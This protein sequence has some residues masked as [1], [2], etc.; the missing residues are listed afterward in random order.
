[1]A[2]TAVANNT[3]ALAVSK[4]GLPFTALAP[5]TA[6]VNNQ[7][8]AT[9]PLTGQKIA[10][11][12][13]ADDLPAVVLDG[14]KNVYFLYSIALAPLVVSLVSSNNLNDSN[15]NLTA[16]ILQLAGARYNGNYLFAAVQNQAGDTFGAAGSGIALLRSQSSTSGEKEKRITHTLNVLN[17]GNAFSFTGD[18]AALKIG[19]TATI[20]SNSVDLWWDNYLNC[21]YIAVNVQAAD[22]SNGARAV[23]VGNISNNQLT[24]SP[25]APDAALSGANQIVGVNNS[26]TTN[27]SIQKVRT[28]HTST[29]LDY[30]VVVGGNGT[31]SSTGNQVY[32]LPLVRTADSTNGTL[33]QYSSTPTTNSTNGFYRS[34]AYTTAATAPSDLLTNSATAAVVGAGNLPLAA[35]SQPSDIWAIDDTV[36]VSISDAYSGSSTPGIFSSQALFDSAGRVQAWTPWQ[37]VGGSNN[38]MWG[39]G[40]IPTSGDFWFIPGTDAANLT[41]LMRTVWGKGTADGLL[42]GTTSDADVGLVTNLN[43]PLQSLTDF[44]VNTA[45]FNQMALQIATG[46]NTMSLIETGRVSGGYFQPNLG[47]FSTGAVQSTNGSLPTLSSNTKLATVSGGALNQLGPI[48][49]S[50]VASAGT[51]HWLLVG[52]AHGLAVLCDSSGTGWSGT[53]SQLSD[54][55]A[56]LSFKKVGDYQYVTRLISDQNYLYVLTNEK[57]DRIPLN[58]TNFAND[59]LNPVTLAQ[60]SASSTGAP[61]SY[62]DVAISGPLALLASAQGLWRT[63]NGN[64]IS[65]AANQTAVQWTQI[66][67]PSPIGP[68]YQLDALSGT[69]DP[70]GWSTLGN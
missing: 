48:T 8:N 1:T 42:G 3:Y 31:S 21:L 13:L 36:F 65:T 11:L 49:T 55:P 60:P 43:Y 35:S 41:S 23:I 32:A 5:A 50:V 51:D 37:R 63:G 28:M 54:L 44:S 29:Q 70:N 64:D 53:I 39:M 58:S 25:I 34:R 27:V 66:D 24:F 40:Y 68:V 18:L 33:A 7:E 67:L 69:T 38:Q 62:F 17:N 19:A 12:G 14:A 59:T 26:A 22:A 20:T 10:L 47:N 6:L 2:N 46:L 57:L 9:N 56:N 61:N 4:N 30:L 52:G 45:G 15:G 16:S